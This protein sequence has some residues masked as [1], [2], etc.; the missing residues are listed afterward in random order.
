MRLDKYA[1]S[2]IF[3]WNFPLLIIITKQWADPLSR[4]HLFKCIHPGLIGTIKGTE[5]QKPYISLY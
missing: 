2:Q 5:L 1:E 4:A 3:T